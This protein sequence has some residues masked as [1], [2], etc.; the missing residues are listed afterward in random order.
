MALA[1]QLPCD[2]QQHSCHAVII[3]AIAIHLFVA[4]LGWFKDN[5]MHTDTEL[6]HC[7]HYVI[8]FCKSFVTFLNVYKLACRTWLGWTKPS[9]GYVTSIL[10][11]VLCFCVNAKR[12]QIFLQTLSSLQKFEKSHWCVPFTATFSKRRKI[13]ALWSERCDEQQSRCPVPVVNTIIYRP[14]IAQTGSPPM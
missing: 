13:G 2:F 7:D 4:V 6:K 12:A 9:H 14:F 10:Y 8:A 11:T 1:S 5:T 3:D